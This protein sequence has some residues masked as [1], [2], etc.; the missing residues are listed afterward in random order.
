MK[1]FSILLVLIFTCLTAWSQELNTQKL[2][3]L[4]DSLYHYNKFMGSVAIA[5][6]GE[7]IYTKSVGFESISNGKKANTQTKYGIGSISKTFTSVLTHMAIENGLLSLETPLSKFYPKIKHSEKI[8]ISMLLNHR[9]GIHNFTNDYEEYMSYNT[10]AKSEDEMI[11]IIRKGGSEFKPDSKAEYS[12]SNYVLLSFILEKVYKQSYADLIQKRICIPLNLKNTLVRPSS[13]K[14][15]N[16]ASS[17]GRSNDWDKS[18]VTHSSVPLGAGAIISTPSD[19]TKFSHALFHGDLVSKKSLES[20]MTL[21]DNYGKGLFSFPFEDK[22][23]Y[24][25]TGGIDGFS[26]IFGDFVDQDYSFALIS[27]GLNYDLNQ[28]GILALSELFGKD[29]EIPNLA[30]AE[31]ESNVL[32]KYVGKYKSSVLPI[33]IEIM[34]SDDGVLYAQGSGQP[35]FPLEAKSD[36]RFVFTQAGVEFNFAKDGSGFEMEQGGQVFGFIKKK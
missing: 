8:N 25:H 26:S 10:Q 32:E 28:I 31:V 27:N 36:T 1:N 30:T 22:K 2:D 34:L 16:C 23:S 24:G 6:K 9:S 33:D 7:V 21:K 4:F 15:E 19:L 11:K 20:M 3:K 18:T 12:N 35:K 29:W 14:C 17:Y 13:G 5:Q